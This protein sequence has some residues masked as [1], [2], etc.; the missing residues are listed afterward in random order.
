MS[1]QTI[2]QNCP[3]CGSL[4]RVLIQPSLT[5][6]ESHVLTDCQNVTCDLFMVTLTAGKHEMLTTA[7]IEGYGR[8]RR[9]ALARE[10]KE[11]R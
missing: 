9:E 2:T 3:C 7:Q 10:G 5:G 4:M 11:R 1:E 8:A 6:K